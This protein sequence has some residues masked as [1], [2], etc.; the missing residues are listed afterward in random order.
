VS[1]PASRT[2][3]VTGASRGLGRHLATGLVDAGLS[4]ALLVRDRA[5]GERVAADLRPRLADGARCGVVVADVTDHAQVEAAAREAVDA[6]GP[7]DLLVNN[8]GVIE[9]TEV[10]AWEE[11]PATWRTV[12]EADLLG[13]FHCV[14]ALVPAMVAQGAG[15][16]V[17][18]SSGAGATDRDVYSAYCAAKAGAFR[19]TGNLHLAGYD[20]GLRA[21]DV[22]PGVVRTDMTGAMAMHDGRTEWTDPHDLVDLVVAVAAGGLDAWSGRYLRAGVDTPASLRAA[23]TGL[24]ERARRLRVQALGPDDTAV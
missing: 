12:V 4:L 9:P 18:V 5:A 19:L 14:R 2:A 3:L 22:S 11:D 23:E 15:R 20:R 8:A 21:F 7:V 24:D 10:P 1:V 16:V 17:T 13:P 6:L